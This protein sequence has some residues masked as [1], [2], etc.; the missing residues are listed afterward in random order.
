M[1][2]LTARFGGIGDQ[3]D[4]IGLEDELTP[5]DIHVVSLE[6][7]DAKRQPREFNKLN[8]SATER[9]V[10]ITKHKQNDR[11]WLDNRSQAMDLIKDRDYPGERDTGIL[12][13]IL[14][15]KRLRHCCKD[16]ETARAD[17]P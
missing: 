10:T 17:Q 16:H 6:R 12:L 3:P 1:V 5:V 8:V 11:V 9:A 15:V 7:I 4:A 2:K 14:K 13:L